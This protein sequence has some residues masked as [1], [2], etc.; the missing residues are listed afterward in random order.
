MKNIKSLT[1]QDP[2]SDMPCTEPEMYTNVSLFSF[3]S[4]YLS[5]SFM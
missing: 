1:V 5:Y 2:F 3:C 4:F